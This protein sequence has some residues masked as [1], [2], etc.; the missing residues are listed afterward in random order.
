MKSMHDADRNDHDQRS[1]KSSPNLAQF[2]FRLAAR[3]EQRLRQGRM[4]VRTD[5]PIVMAAARG[6]RFAMDEFVSDSWRPLA[7]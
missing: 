6:K 3:E 5:F 4:T 7:I 2:D 1:G